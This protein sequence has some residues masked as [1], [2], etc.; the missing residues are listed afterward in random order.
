MCDPAERHK[1]L[2][3]NSRRQHALH[4]V[5]G[6]SR[7][8]PFM[9][10]LAS[11]DRHLEPT[12]TAGLASG[13]VELIDRLASEWRAL[14]DEGPY[15]APFFRPEWIRAYVNAFAPGKRV[16]IVTIR[17]GSQ[18]IGVLPLIR[19][20]GLTAGFPSRK[21]RSAGNIHTQRYDVIHAADTA[22][23]VIPPIWNALESL[24]G[25]DVLEL[26]NVPLGGAASALAR[27]ARTRGYDVHALRAATS[28]YIALGSNALHINA[29]FHANLRRRQ[30]RLERRG[31]VRLLVTRSVNEQLGAFYELE[32]R[33]WKGIEQS[34]IACNSSTRLFY[35]E[36]ANAAAQFKYLSLYSL[37]CAG[38]AVAMHFGVEH[39]GRYFLLKTAYDETLRDCSPGQLITHRVLQELIAAGCAEFDFLGVTMEWKNAWSPQLRPHADWYVMRGPTG[40]L[41]DRLRFSVA[42]ILGRRIRR[43]R[44]GR[45]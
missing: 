45:T 14:C 39:G 8:P 15:D 19:E 28:P 36:I 32:Q 26:S 10:S 42:P 38:Q 20:N 17:K 12:I 22:E 44:A 7:S 1:I 40:R 24:S 18:L 23:Q 25:W 5:I 43:W 9:S 27:Y 30:R 4:R 2:R 35:D 21:L 6:L 33:G 29:K 34:A 31:P 3:I 13:G 37:E 16:V 11:F 41:L